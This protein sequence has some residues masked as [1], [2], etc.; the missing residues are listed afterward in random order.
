MTQEAIDVAVAEATGESRRTITR[1]GFS[2]AN[3]VEVFFDPEPH[4]SDPRYVDWDELEARW[5]E[6]LR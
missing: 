3:P 5:R 2:L 6:P 4:E 1:R